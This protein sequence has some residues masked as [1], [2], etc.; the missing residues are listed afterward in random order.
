MTEAASEYGLVLEEPYSK[1]IF[2]Q[3]RLVEVIS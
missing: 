1:A 3:F 2:E